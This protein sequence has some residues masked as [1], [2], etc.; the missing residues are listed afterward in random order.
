MPQRDG[1]GPN[2]EGPMTGGGFG[3]CEGVSQRGMG[4]GR[5]GRHFYGRGARR[6]RRQGL[7]L[8]LGRAVVYDEKESEQIKELKGQ[9]LELTN[10]VSDLRTALKK[11]K[12]EQKASADTSAGGN[13]EK[14]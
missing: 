9:I 3:P 10:A 11:T 5:G 2:G 13:T 4:R 6:R 1:T 8:G 12:A 14:K 7:G